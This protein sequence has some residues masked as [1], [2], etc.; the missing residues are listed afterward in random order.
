MAE[1]PS[2][3]VT[4]LFTDIEGSTRLLHELRERYGEVLSEHARI[5]R[6]A[7]ADHEGREIDTQGDSFFVAFRTAKD[8]LAAAVAA[9]QGLA[10]NP[11]VDGGPPAVRM[12]M[13][14]GEPAV[15]G[16]RYL[17]LA[18]HRASRICSAAYGGQILL[19]GTTADL[20]ADELPAGTSLRDL[21][22]HKLK[23]FERPE[24]VFQ[25]VTDGLR[26]DFP[27]LATGPASAELEGFSGREG[28]LAEAAEAAVGELPARRRIRGPVRFASAVGIAALAIAISIV[29]VLVGRGGAGDSDVSGTVPSKSVVLID[30]TRNAVSDS[31]ALDTSPSSL[32]GR[33]GDLWI[34]N[35]ADKILLRV[36]ARTRKVVKAIGLG[37]TPQA[38]TTTAG[39]VWVLGDGYPSAP[40]LQ[41]TPATGDVTEAARPDCCDGVGLLA[42]DDQRLWV[43]ASDSATIQ[44]F[45]PE[46]GRLG[47]TICCD[48]GPDALAVGGDTLWAVER[49]DQQ[50]VRM[51]PDTG[52]TQAKIPLGAPLPPGRNFLG[53]EVLSAAVASQAGAW[54]LD[55]AGGQVWQIDPVQNTVVRTISVGAGAKAIALGFG[56]VWVANPVTQTVLRIDPSSG[57]VIR[58]IKVAARLAGIATAGGAVWVAVG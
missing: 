10:A 48:V 47:P 6:T 26:G 24:R 13:H 15:A 22:E 7:F 58:R 54:V 5:L 39:A 4:F 31:I 29:A 37:T 33:G 38:V 36:D 34:T 9:Q 18:V 46:S 27:P 56:S 23:D 52:S 8:A 49:F 42:G 28:E 35:A 16:E 11:W 44:R 43:S 55:S 12:G 41:V 17:G 40:L 50:I 21:G 1:L 32:V 2:G 45:D 19:S 20:V 14:T 3:T 57:G 30:P 51:D 25:V 53:S